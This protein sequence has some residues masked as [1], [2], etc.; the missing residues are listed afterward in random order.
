M[1]EQVD[2]GLTKSIGLSNFNV[3]Q[4]QRI[5]DNCRIKPDAVQNENHLYLQE[6][7]FVKFCY[8]NR[9]RMIAYASLGTNGVRK[10]MNMSWT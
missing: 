4:I 10:S 8:D 7:E 5:L 1:E 3:K 9:I 2:N 6:P